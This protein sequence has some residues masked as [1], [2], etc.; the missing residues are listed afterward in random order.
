MGLNDKSMREAVKK[1]ILAA[2]LPRGQHWL[3]VDQ[4]LAAAEKL[5]DDKNRRNS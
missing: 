5:D 3:T 2:D 4:L 1:L